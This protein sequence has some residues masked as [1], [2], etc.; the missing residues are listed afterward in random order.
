MVRA[1]RLLAIITVVLAA[2]VGV[3]TPSMANGTDYFVYSNFDTGLWG[4]Y[5]VDG[6]VGQDGI[7]RIIFYSLTGSGATAYIYK[8]TIPPGSNPNMHPDNPEATG[9][10]APRTFTLEKTFDLGAYPSHFCEFYVDAANNI[11]YLGAYVGIR[12]YVYDTGLGNYVYAGDVA[13]PS[14]MEEGYGTQ[15]LA[16]NPA[17]DTWYAGSI[18]WNGD[19]GV[20]LRDMWKYEGSQGPAGIW[21]LAF[22]YTTPEG[23]SSHH[24]GLEF[25]GGYLWLADYQGDYIKQYSVNG[26]LIKAFWHQA[27]GHEL[28]GMGFGALG[29]FWCGSHGSIITEFGGAGLGVQ[30]VNIDIKPW[31]YPNS[32]NLRDNKGV[33]PV[34]ILGNESLDVTS[35][36]VTSLRFGPSKAKPT[37]DLTNPIVYGDHLQDVNGDGYID[38]VSHYRTKDTGLTVGDTS[39]CLIGALNDSTP[40]NGCDSV[41]I[42]K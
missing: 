1:W 16:Y 32:I 21:E 6:Y 9:P 35:V 38:L 31:S 10:I 19:P 24:D 5:G 37:H 7:S 20:T 40:I 2:L 4:S 17:T 23:I 13:P 15:S 36:D 30:T 39:A 25:V 33:I 42:V 18:A 8:V 12:K 26:T 22:Q 3:A 41:R 28:E 11:I 14:P 29:H 27:L 34:A